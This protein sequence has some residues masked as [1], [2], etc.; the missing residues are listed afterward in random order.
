MKKYLVLLFFCAVMMLIASCEKQECAC[1]MWTDGKN[2]DTN[3]VV[4]T[5]DEID[6]LNAKNCAGLNDYYNSLGLGY[7]ETVK[8]GIKCE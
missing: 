5:Q 6:R 2:T 7:D 8:S 1:F 3:P 4:Y